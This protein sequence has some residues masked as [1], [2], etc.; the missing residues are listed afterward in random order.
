MAP[1]AL[2]SIELPLQWNSKARGNYSQLLRK[3]RV[4]ALVKPSVTPS[5]YLVVAQAAGAPGGNGMVVLSW[6]EWG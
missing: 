3:S 6:R 2:N 1:E 5:N 4:G